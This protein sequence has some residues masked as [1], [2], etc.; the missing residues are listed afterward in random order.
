LSW[1]KAG[2]EQLL[3]LVPSGIALLAT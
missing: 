2:L 1:K 3:A